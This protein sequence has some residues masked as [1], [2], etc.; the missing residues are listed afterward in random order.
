[1]DDS[2]AMGTGP[3]WRKADIVSYGISV[4]CLGDADRHFRVFDPG[5]GQ[6][7]SR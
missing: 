4:W 7:R 5:I 2:N 6:D 3:E 1:M